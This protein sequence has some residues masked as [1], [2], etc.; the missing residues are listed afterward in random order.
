M[1]LGMLATELAATVWSVVA[2]NRLGRQRTPIRLESSQAKSALEQ[3]WCV[4]RNTCFE[5]TV[6]TTNNV[7][8]KG[9]WINR[10]TGVFHLIY[11]V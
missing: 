11:K 10:F 1:G 2:W 5:R 8:S 4:I 6:A 3:R 7:S 9:A